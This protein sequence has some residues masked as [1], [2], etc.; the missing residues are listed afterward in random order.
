[1][2]RLVL[3][4]IAAELSYRFVEVPI[5]NGAFTRWRQ[6]LRRRE[7]V[8][9]RAGPVALAGAA[10]LILVAVNTV[11]ASGTSSLEQLTS[12]GDDASAGT[13]SAAFTT[14]T[15]DPTVAPPTSSVSSGSVAGVEGTASATSLAPTTAGPTTSP[16][17]RAKT[18]TV[19][20]D[21]VLL[22]AKD[23]M[24]AELQASGYSVDYRAVPALM[25]HIASKDL[26]AA[27]TPVGETVICG[28]GHNSLW[29]RDRANYDKWARKFDNEA[30]TL[31]QTLESL[32]AK[33]IIW[34]TLREPSES[35]IPPSGMKQFRAYVW[36]FPYVNERLRLLPQRHPDV[37]LAD[38]AAVS[39][40]KGL[41]YDAMHLTKSGTRLMIDTI[42]SAGGL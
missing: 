30:D 23:Q 12:Q 14:T 9:R 18:I 21:S 11:G 15:T 5:R 42:R 20:G 13:A 29:E 7:G 16:D 40:Q 39:N 32:G 2:V 10:G 26:L 1:V 4:V 19:L 24:T 33:R 27:D 36:Y 6:R 22:G 3:T 8:R 41:T 37:V 35:V 31:I 17:P 38:W 25:V 34:V 28:L